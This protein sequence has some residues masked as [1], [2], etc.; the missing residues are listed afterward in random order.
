MYRHACVV[1]LQ[2]GMSRI[3]TASAESALG[4]PL[5]RH[6]TCLPFAKDYKPHVLI[7]FLI[8]SFRHFISLYAN[9]VARQSWFDAQF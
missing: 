5:G 4:G 2:G 8:C 9:D 1:S 6:H 3:L 7:G